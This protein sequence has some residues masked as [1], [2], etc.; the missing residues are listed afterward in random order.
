MGQQNK[1][2]SIVISAITLLLVSACGGG[3]GGSSA[4]GTG[5][6]GGGTSSGPPPADPFGLAQRE[7]LA[8]F[9]LPSDPVGLG[10]YELEASFP[11]LGGFSQALFVAG[12]PGQDRLAVV[13]Q[14]GQ[15][16]AFTDDP[17]VSD[18]RLV[19]DIS[20][21]IISG[22]EEGLLGL[23]FDPDFSQNGYVYVHYSVSGPRRSIIARFTWDSVADLILPASEKLI[24]EVPQPFSNHNGGMLAFGPDGYLY[25][26]FGDGGS[27]GDPQNNAQNPAN[28][29]GS[30]VRIDVHPVN[31]ADR[32]DV[33]ADNPFIG[34]SGFLPETYAYGLRNPFRFSF[35]RQTGELWLADVGQSERE[36]VNL[37][38][39]GENFGWRV[40]EG[41]LP[42]D[43]SLNTLPQSA[44]TPPVI[45][46]DHGQGISVIGGYV[47]R[48]SGNPGLTGRYL[49]TDFLSGPVWALDYAN[50]QLLAN[51][52]IAT[53]SSSNKSFGEGN[54]GELYLLVGTTINHFVE[55]VSGGGTIPDQLSETGIFTSLPAL[56]PASGL[57]EYELNAPFW[58][59]GALKRRW[60]GVPDAEQVT[61][62]ATGS[63]VFPVG[64]LLVKHFELELTEGSPS[65]ARRLETRLLVRTGAGWQ[66]FTYRWLP[67]ESDALLLA[68]R[69]TETI[70]VA[71]SG[72][73]TRDQRYEYPS[74]TDC[75]GCHND[76]AGFALG[77]EARQQNRDFAYAAATDNQ[78][79][80]WNH[81]ELFTNDIGEATQYAKYPSLADTSA[82]LDERAR[83]YLDVNCASCHQPGGPTPVTLDLRFDTALAS[84]A[85]LNVVPSAGDLGIVEARII[86]P[87][88]RSRSVLWQR[89]Q[90]LDGNRM[91]PLSSHLVDEDAVTIIGDWI[92]SL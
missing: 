3:G 20:G 80:S 76:A 69:E 19:L 35:D 72:G 71:L 24:L 84:T 10:S 33:P 15:I 29:L 6:G 92:D 9:S 31:A 60:V 88:D 51:D 50:G 75:L 65:S 74:R 28:F 90:L 4:P 27:G 53:T 46:Y 58:S 59:D 37:V 83:V 8:S 57:I 21:Q 5:T 67:D 23:A 73:G 22:G 26:A 43:D 82:G 11:N 64:T 52:V 36:E 56:T 91:P 61:F 34:R 47:Y 62:S 13:Q 42:F 7:P 78:L 70:T 1:V 63:W 39:G 17:A 77:L 41:N 85:A 86:A 18:S 38:T 30:I 54:D 40:F 66:G 44:F 68:G 12:V 25:I 16:R 45:D 87:G 55:T 81:I 49:Y 14:S 32:Y 89:M 2:R 79:R 48:G